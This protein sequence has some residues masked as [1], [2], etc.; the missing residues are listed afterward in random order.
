MV[1][2]SKDVITMSAAPTRNK[3]SIPKLGSFPRGVLSTL[4]HLPIN[5]F[6]SIRPRVTVAVEEVEE[7]R[8]ESAFTDDNLSPESLD[9]NIKVGHIA[10][11]SQLNS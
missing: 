3:R 11:V 1:Q 6:T 5:S 7:N 8:S 9:E 4:C 2:S 10:S